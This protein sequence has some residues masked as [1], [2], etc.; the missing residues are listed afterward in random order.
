[1]LFVEAV[2]PKE[3]VSTILVFYPGALAHAVLYDVINL[4]RVYTNLFM[5]TS[6]F[7]CNYVGIVADGALTVTRQFDLP[8]LRIESL[9]DYNF[10]LTLYSGEQPH[11]FGVQILIASVPVKLQGNK[12]IAKQADLSRGT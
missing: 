5:D 2:S 10:T 4:D 8:I 6:G 9:K 7:I 11:K 3:N 12:T 1:L